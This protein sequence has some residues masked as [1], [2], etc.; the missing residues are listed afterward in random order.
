MVTKGQ[1]STEDNSLTCIVCGSQDRVAL[2][3]HRVSDAVSGIFCFCHKCWPKYSGATLRTEWIIDAGDVAPK[4]AAEAL[5][6]ST[7]NAR[8]EI[9]PL[10]KDAICAI[11]QC[12]YEVAVGQ[13]RKALARLSSIA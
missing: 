11:G 2:V 13:I 8:S 9:E 1:L 10:L 12:A 3:P 5:I 4:D 6:S 7:N